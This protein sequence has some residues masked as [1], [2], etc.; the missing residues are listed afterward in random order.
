MGRKRLEVTPRARTVFV[1]CGCLPPPS[2]EA[3]QVAIPISIR[4][5]FHSLGTQPDW[6]ARP[7]DF[8]VRNIRNFSSHL[9]KRESA[10]SPR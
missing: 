1:P 6:N 10:A 8:S 5:F 7:G 9:V 2:V 3:A 4:R